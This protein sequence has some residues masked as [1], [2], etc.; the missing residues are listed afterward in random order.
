MTATAPSKH[1]RGAVVRE[2]AQPKADRG[3]GN[4]TTPMIGPGSGSTQMINGLT[5]I[6]PGQQI[7][8]HYHNCEEA[9]LV[10][11]GDAVVVIDKVEHRMTAPD[12]SWVAAGVPHYFRNPSSTR[13][14]TIFWTYASIEA[15][16]TLVETGET[17][18][19]A[20]EHA[21]RVAAT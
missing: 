8:E 4:R 9:I 1:P 13:P 17:R 2:A 11:E 16:R 15:T 5:V 18:P 21:R 10:V 7:Q 12:A 14:L 19:I 3:G 20:A 6:A